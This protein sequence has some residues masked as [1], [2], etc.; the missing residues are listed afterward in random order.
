MH[1]AVTTFS[2]VNSVLFV[3]LAAL[4]LDRWLKRRDRAAGW[5]V[6]SFLALG[7]I[8]TVGRLV[9]VRPHSLVLDGAQRFDIEL[10]VLFPYLLYRFATEFVP[11]SRRLQRIVG[12]LTIGLSL[13]TFS[14][15]RV[16]AAGDPRPAWFLAYVL[17]FLAHWTLL[18]IVVTVRL[19]RA[20]REQP[21]VAASRMRM[22]SFAA[23]ALTAAI[24]G[25][26]FT[27]NQHALAALV[28]QVVA[29]A[30]CVGFVL[31]LSPPQIIRAYWRL[32]EQQRMQEAITG[33]MTL[34]TTRAEVAQ[35]VLAPA[36]ALVGARGAAI[37]D[38]DGSTV[39]EHAVPLDGE[40][41]R[42]EQ[43]G[44]TL[45]VWTSAYA[46]F[47]GEDELRL[48]DTVT[49][50]T[51]IAL[52][53]V[54]LFEQEHASR[55]ALERANE[56]MTNF[57]AL[58]AHELRTPVTTVHGFVQTLNHLGDRLGEEQQE[59]LRT[60]LGQQ[61]TRMAALVEQLLDLSRLDAEAIDIRPQAVDLSSRLAEVVTVAA[62][63]R[64]AE[65]EVHVTGPTRAVIDP[66][67][68]DHI[69]TNLVTNA[70]RYGLA[71]VRVSAAL[72]GGSL[73]VSVEDAGPGVAREIE[74]TLFERFTRAG[75]ARDRV[76]G[77]GLGLAIARA[78][79]RAHRGDLR[80]EPGQPTGAR[81]VVELPSV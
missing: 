62:G 45:L 54:R 63:A 65:V 39:A 6:L 67:V 44:A 73:R 40:P 80:Y 27:S 31:G 42:L 77:T 47:F 79:A 56:V 60:A 36:V 18:S 5:L 11:P 35:R 48:L 14:L 34:A 24:I 8:V 21:S 75:V 30:S 28:V 53:R 10:L 38:S 59:E 57:V 72:E 50:L 22:L 61:T 29:L 32:P 7:L 52:D 49:A 70:L 20:G 74:E 16:P 37:L 43:P 26:A 19:W 17:V 71:P 13:W 25:T 78:Y 64:A 23:A 3:A 69:V 12:V 51:G 2:I 9:P 55:I 68:L 66:S 33:L 41:V 81:F 76:A 15:P 4:A 58:A 1:A 46:P